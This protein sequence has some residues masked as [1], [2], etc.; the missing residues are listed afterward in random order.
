VVAAAGGLPG[1]L[2]KLWRATGPDSYHVEYGYSCMGYEIAGG[3]GVKLAL[4][5]R[6]VFVLVGDGSYLMMNSEIATAVA[7]GLKLVIVV[8]D[9]RGYGCIN[10]L[11]RACGGESYNNLLGDAPAVDF[12]AHARALGA[13][14]ARAADLNGLRAALGHAMQAQRT[15]VI[16][17]ETDP[18]HATAAGGAWWDVPVADVSTS[19]EVQDAGRR[20][21][22]QRGET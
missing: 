3:L 2:H 19:P 20:Y 15:S 10:R 1:E 11:Q 18:Q 7:L 22:Q 13:E 8:L 17:I 5:A 6:D 4:P 12:V 9:N 14:A 16:V 21:R